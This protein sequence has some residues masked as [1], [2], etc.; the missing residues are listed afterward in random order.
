MSESNVEVTASLLDSF[1]TPSMK[2]YVKSKLGMSLRLTLSFQVGSNWG[3][4][5][6]DTGSYSERSLSVL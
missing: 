6:A 3:S 2:L 1:S 5:A 4:E